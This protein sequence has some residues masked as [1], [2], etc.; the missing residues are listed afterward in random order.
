MANTAEEKVTTSLSD[1]NTTANVEDE[2]AEQPGLWNAVR[3]SLRGTH[4]DYTTGPIGR[5]IILLA[6][7]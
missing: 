7:P 4:R 5:S 6:I 2:P 1:A 3:E